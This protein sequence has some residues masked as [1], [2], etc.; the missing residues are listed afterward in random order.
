MSLNSSRTSGN[1]ALEQWKRGR[2]RS[3]VECPVRRNAAAGQPGQPWPAVQLRLRRHRFS[4]NLR[5]SGRQWSLLCGRHGRARTSV[6]LRQSAW[7]AGLHGRPRSQL[8]GRSL[9]LPEYG[10]R[11]GWHRPLR[12]L[13][14]DPWFLGSE[15]TLMRFYRGKLVFFFVA[16]TTK[17]NLCKLPK[18]VN[19][20][21]K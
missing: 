19:F 5:R 4:G 1:S 7:A 15:E 21:L 14:L 16:L 3:L 6:L 12:D 9:R 11:A 20:L 17:L 2:S 10:D 18:C 13:R 8:S